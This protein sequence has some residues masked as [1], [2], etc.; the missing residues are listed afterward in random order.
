ML[1]L[2]LNQNPNPN[3]IWTS[4]TTNIS[5]ATRRSWNARPRTN[6]PT[7][8]LVKRFME[9]VLEHQPELYDTLLAIA[10]TKTLLE[11]QEVLGIGDCVFTRDRKWLLQLKQAFEDGG[12]IRKHKEGH[13]NCGHQS[14]QTVHNQAVPVYPLTQKPP[15]QLRITT[16]CETNARRDLTVRGSNETLVVDLTDW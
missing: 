9:Y 11:A 14:S 8:K 13:T 12:P 16:R 1:R 10:E 3:L 4:V 6:A 5:T 15:W 2:F 7:W